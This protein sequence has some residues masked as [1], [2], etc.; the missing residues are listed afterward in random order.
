MEN[1]IT[2]ASFS[3][4]TEVVKSL[5]E[6]FY[7]EMYN[8][9][10]DWEILIEFIICQG[11]SNNPIQDKGWDRKYVEITEKH[12]FPESWRGFWGTNKFYDHGFI[13]QPDIEY[14]CRG[15]LVQGKRWPKFKETTTKVA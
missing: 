5:R 13:G 15:T 12:P 1:K 2:E 10:T 7:D 4:F 11:D 8:G 3:S 6:W 9:M 14:V